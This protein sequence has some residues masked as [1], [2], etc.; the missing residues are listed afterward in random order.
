[1]RDDASEKVCAGMTVMIGKDAGRPGRGFLA[2]DPV[3]RA[4]SEPEWG[5]KRLRIASDAVAARAAL[6]AR[7]RLRTLQR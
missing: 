3:F 2:A 5:A 6:C 7:R 1:M 4:P